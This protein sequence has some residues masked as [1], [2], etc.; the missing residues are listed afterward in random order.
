MKELRT[1]ARHA[2]TVYVGQAAVLAFGITD[3]L[4]ASRYSGQALAA[5]GVGS[6]LYISIYVGLMGLISAQ[7]PVWAELRGAGKSLQV[8]RSVRQALYLAAMAC[9]VGVALL[10]SPDAILRWTEVPPE[11]RGEVGRYLA[12][13]AG[14]LP[15]ALLFRLYSTLSQALGRPLL[16]T[17]IQV[18]ALAVKVPLSIWLAFGGL[19][20]PDLGLAGCA[21]ASAVVYALMAAIAAW[22]VRTQDF[23][24]P[25]RIWAAVERPHGPTLR[26]FA[27]LG[28]PTALSIVVEVTSFTLMALFIARQGVVA[29]ASH[30][31]AASLAGLLYMM[32]LSLGIATSARVS[33][34]I[35]AADMRHARLALRLGLKLSLGL[36][37]ACALAIAMLDQPLARVYAGNN[38]PVVALAASLLPLVAAYHLFDAVQCVC[39]FV[40]RCFGVATS[41]VV[42]YSVLLWGLGLGGGFAL[43]YHGLAGWGP[44]QS[45]AAFWI[46]ATVALAVTAVAFIGLLWRAVRARP[47]A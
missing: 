35:G 25:Y 4:V 40:L 14:T 33:Y 7:L 26:G 43:A 12:I 29:A 42:V 19:G 5:L 30:Q 11:L 31:V 10:L 32:P 17:W 36:A 27:R 9:L 46:A 41:P 1:I 2:G 34:W 24:T 22:T 23:F 45:P 3:T 37:L 13:A 6:A 38:P 15:L 28:V 44:M 20:M 18:G 21:W 16:V 47:V 8:G 39:V